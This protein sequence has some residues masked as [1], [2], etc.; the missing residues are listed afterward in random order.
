MM[1]R[2]NKPYFFLVTGAAA[3]ALL[4]RIPFELPGYTRY[5]ASLT[6]VLGLPRMEKTAE[7]ILRTGDRLQRRR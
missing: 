4:G 6:L 7:T 5:L 1:A 2:R 3:A